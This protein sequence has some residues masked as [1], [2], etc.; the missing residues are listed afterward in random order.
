MLIH[1][2]YPSSSRDALSVTLVSGEMPMPHSLSANLSN[3]K[4][5]IPQR[6]PQSPHTISVYVAETH[7][8]NHTFN[9]LQ[10]VTGARGEAG[11][12]VGIATLVGLQRGPSAP[13]KHVLYQASGG[14]GVCA[15]GPVAQNRLLAWRLPRPVSVCFAAPEAS[16]RA[17]TLQDTLDVGSVDVRIGAA[18][19]GGAACRTHLFFN[20]TPLFPP[21][22][23][24]TMWFKGFP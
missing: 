5:C 11:A 7:S 17:L 1:T 14:N 24:A 16:G 6:Y 20:R 23:I 13:A 15:R 2:L 4:S 8:D 9:H 12:P 3:G 22:T 18:Q 19:H 21:A 10:H